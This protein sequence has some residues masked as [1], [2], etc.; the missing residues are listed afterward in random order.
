MKNALVVI[1]VQNYFVNEETKNLP[2]KIA[3]YIEENKYDFVVFTKFVNKKGS[4][5]FKLLN[6]NKMTSSPATDIHSALRKFVKDNNVFEKNTYS[7]FK[8]ED[9]LNFLKK[10]NIIKIY[11]CGLDIDSCV[12]ASAF[13]AFD[14][15]YEVKV[16]EN[17]SYSHYGDD[18]HKFGVKIIE[19]DIQKGE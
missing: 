15:G 19:K 13:E 1:D 10:N 18:F 4:N 14:L 17:L 12:L 8:S 11:L 5:W 7:I 6:W 3:G 9:F 16:L 2:V